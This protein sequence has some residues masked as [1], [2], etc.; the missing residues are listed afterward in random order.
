MGV[1]SE[2]IGWSQEA[3][4]LRQIAKQLDRLIKVAGSPQT[5]TTTTTLP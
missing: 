5:T 1:P 4:L 3:K 2:Q